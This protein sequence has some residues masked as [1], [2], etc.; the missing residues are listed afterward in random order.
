MGCPALGSRIDQGARK[1]RTADPSGCNG[2]LPGTTPVPS[3]GLNR[4]PELC[5][6]AWPLQLPHTRSKIDPPLLLIRFLETSLALDLPRFH[7]RLAFGV[8]GV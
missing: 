3:T 2:A 5:L 8:D 6:P 1:T 4:T 7:G